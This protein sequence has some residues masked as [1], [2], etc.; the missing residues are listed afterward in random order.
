MYVAT[1][2]CETLM[3]AKEAI[4]DKLQGSVATYLMCDGTVNNQLKKGLL[5][6]LWPRV[7]GPLFWPTPVCSLSAD[8]YGAERDSGMP[9]LEHTPA[10]VT[11]H[12]GAAMS[13][14]LYSLNRYPTLAVFALPSVEG[15][16]TANSSAQQQSVTGGFRTEKK[17]P[18]T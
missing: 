2:P 1:L 15:P 16:G 7:C 13:H 17:R 11:P 10:E 4:N 5:T 18:R 8:G 9:R 6:E 14:Q 3:S 12:P